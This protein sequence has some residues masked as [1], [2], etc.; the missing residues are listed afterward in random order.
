MFVQSKIEDAAVA[1]ISGSLVSGSITNWNIYQGLSNNLVKFP[2]VKVMCHATT[3][4]TPKESNSGVAIAKLELLACAVKRN[5]TNSDSIT[6]EEFETVSDLVINPFLMD[7]IATTMQLNTNN[8]KFHKV[9]ENG[10]NVETFQDGWI[11]T[12]Q[13]EIVCGRTA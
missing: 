2:C 5:A 13:F 10:L 7:D 12:Q 4:L 3:P 8:M 1:I 6:P 11:A 9:S